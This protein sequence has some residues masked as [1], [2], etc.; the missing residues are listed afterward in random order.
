MSTCYS[1]LPS[2][3]QNHDILNDEPANDQKDLLSSH[4]FI[5]NGSVPTLMSG[6]YE[7]D[8]T[9]DEESEFK[10]GRL[11]RQA[12]LN[13]SH[14]STPQQTTKLMRASSSFPR[15]LSQNP[16]TNQEKVMNMR[17]VE[18][19][20]ERNR[21]KSS[22]KLGKNINGGAP[23]IPAGGWVDKGSSEDMKAQIKFWA[24]AVAFNLHQEC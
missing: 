17:K 3:V 6:K 2:P 16:E 4:G 11:I 7:E 19:M 20:N 18:S 14:M 23:T 13:S 8:D 10:M 12:S 21:N 22:L 9:E 15:Y 24:R 5:E 1:N